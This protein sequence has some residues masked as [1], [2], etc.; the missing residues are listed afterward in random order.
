MSRVP[1]DELDSLIRQLHDVITEAQN[2]CAEISNLAPI[3]KARIMLIE[4]RS[5][6]RQPHTTQH[7]AAGGVK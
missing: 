7:C 6:M 3:I 2:E 4:A 1:D 5:R